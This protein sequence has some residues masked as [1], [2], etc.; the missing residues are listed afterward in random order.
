M[1]GELNKP[2]VDNTVA[3]DYHTRMYSPVPINQSI[4]HVYP[5]VIVH[6]TVYSFVTPWFHWWVAYHH[7]WH[8]WWSLT[9]RNCLYLWQMHEQLVIVGYRCHLVHSAD[10]EYHV[11][12][13]ACQIGLKHIRHHYG[14]NGICFFHQSLIIY[15]TIHQMVF[16]YF[17]LYFVL[18][19][20]IKNHVKTGQKIVQ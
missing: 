20:N 19:N 7:W 4:N 10:L 11:T 13:T 15:G 3:D 6:C 12:K 2:T 9:Q 8:I 5:T 1:H 17:D 18:F 14:F 16:G